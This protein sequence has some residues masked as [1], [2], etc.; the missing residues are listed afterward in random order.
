MVEC[1]PSVCKAM[2]L[3]LKDRE[4]N[5]RELKNEIV[6]MHLNLLRLVSS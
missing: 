5:V 2:G 1:L 6:Y 3:V 4:K